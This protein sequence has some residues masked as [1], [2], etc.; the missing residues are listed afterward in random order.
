MIVNIKI[1]M[2]GTV[3]FDGK[4]A[5]MRK[6]QDF[7]VY[8]MQNEGQNNAARIQSDNRSGFIRLDDGTVWLAKG[9]H[10][11]QQARGT[12]VDV[13]SAE[14]LMMFKAEILASASPKAGRNGVVFCDNSG[15]AN[16]FSV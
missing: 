3:S 5:G 16:V 13:L 2:M 4:F 8:P 15:A 1:N 14:D 6:A 11:F 12:K 9:A 7:I 10:N